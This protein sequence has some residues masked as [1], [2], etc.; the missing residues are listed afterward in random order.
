MTVQNKQNKKLNLESFNFVSLIAV[1]AAFVI[2]FLLSN[3][4]SSSTSI[5]LFSM[6]TL[7]L[8][9]GAIVLLAL[10]KKYLLSIIILFLYNV[11]T[12]MSDFVTY[13]RGNGKDGYT[14][15]ILIF[16]VLL[17][18]YIIFVFVMNA[19]NYNKDIHIQRPSISKSKL[20]GY[21]VI[22]CFLAYGALFGSFIVSFI[23]SIILLILLYSKEELAMGLVATANSVYGISGYIIMFDYSKKNAMFH[24]EYILLI[25]IVVYFIVYT[26]LVAVKL[27]NNNNTTT[28]KVVVKKV[29]T[30]KTEENSQ[31]PTKTTTKSNNNKKAKTK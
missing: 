21:I 23:V 2:H 26:I 20:L 6:L 27:S 8:F 11:H 10:K 16:H 15:F 30:N 31:K 4:R 14:I 18:A 9:A 22:I 7:A 3:T 24:I 29:E 1:G 28:K 17:L 12:A 5:I 13:L 25:A 19:I